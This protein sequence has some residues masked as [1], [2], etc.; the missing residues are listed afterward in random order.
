MLCRWCGMESETTDICSWCRKPLATPQAEQPQAGQAAAE[1]PP[2]IAAPQAPPPGAP[3]IPRPAGV[4]PFPPVPAARPVQ[5]RPI[6]P[7]APERPGR[8]VLLVGLILGG[9]AAV[10]VLILALV[11]T[12]QQKMREVREWTTYT[13][14]EELFTV[15]MP[16]GWQTLESSAYGTETHVWIQQSRFVRFEVDA[17]LITSAVGDVATSASRGLSELTGASAPGAGTI[18]THCFFAEVKKK[19]MKGRDYEESYP[20]L[21]RVAGAEAAVSDCSYEGK[22]YLWRPNMKGKRV[23]ILQS[24][25]GYTITAVCPEGEYAAFEPV[26]TRMLTSFR[27]GSR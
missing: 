25:R 6:V 7:V 15:E 5:L 10:I 23:T 18:D 9:S 13:S 12:S 11:Q 8:T 16:A 21:T 1:Q 26:M 17:S 22:G 27:F 2:P 20:D 3:G 24:E 19:T 4:A 14:G